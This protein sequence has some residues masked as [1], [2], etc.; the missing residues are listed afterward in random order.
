M[1][2]ATGRS[3]RAINL[4]CKRR[5]HYYPDA[6]ISQITER[7]AALNGARRDRVAVEGR[8]PEANSD[9]SPVR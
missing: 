2:Y 3:H 1:L 6:D 5:L 4:F 7:G 9:T 8:S